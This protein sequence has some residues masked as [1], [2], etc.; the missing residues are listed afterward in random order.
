VRA[1]IV[2]LLALPALVLCSGC[3]NGVQMSDEE[4]IACRNEGCVVYTEREQR[5][6]VDRVLR[7]GYRRGWRD[8]TVQS[9]RGI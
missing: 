7:E 6:L 5:T 9:G 1:A 4:T 8:A 3:A 2:V